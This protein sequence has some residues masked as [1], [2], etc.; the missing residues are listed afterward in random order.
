MHL[1][2]HE[3]INLFDGNLLSYY[4]AAW[5]NIV[6]TITVAFN[7]NR[8]DLYN[9]YCLSSS[10]SAGNIEYNYIHTCLINVNA[11]TITLSRNRT[12]GLSISD[13]DNY[14]P[15]GDNNLYITKVE[16]WK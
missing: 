10:K 14:T 5:S 15:G 7:E 16:L 4:S 13:D 2:N 12:L 11:K 1:T 8:Q 9:Y 6:P 3:V